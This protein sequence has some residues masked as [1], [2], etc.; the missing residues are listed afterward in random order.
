[1]RR[2]LPALCVLLAGLVPVAHASAQDAPAVSDAQIARMAE[3][4]GQ[5]LPLH[6]VLDAVVAGDPQWPFQDRPE[7]V[8]ATQLA[9][10]RGEM[11]STQLAALLDRRVRTYARSHAARMPGDMELLEGGGA[12]LF[13]KIMLAGMA[14]QTDGIESEAPEA[15]IAQATPQDFAAM[16]ELFRDAQYGPL[17]ELLGFPAHSIDMEQGE[18]T[19]RAVG[20]TFLI[21]MMMDAFTR[22]QVPMSVLTGAGAARDDARKSKTKPGGSH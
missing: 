10:V 16:F 3:L 9:C 19:G 12:R 20:A 21:P 13:S 2:R 1:V 8:D 11:G 4:V 15:L 18:A 22:C 5:T 6:V 14:T 7:V 17:R